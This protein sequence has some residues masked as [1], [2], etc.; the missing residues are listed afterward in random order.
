MS[1]LDNRVSLV[2]ILVGDLDAFVGL[3]ELAP[4]CGECWLRRL[5]QG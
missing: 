1:L 4:G 5:A 2:D 3:C